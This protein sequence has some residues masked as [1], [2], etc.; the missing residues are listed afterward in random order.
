LQ[1]C[2]EEF[3]ITAHLGVW[4]RGRIFAERVG[5]ESRP[6]EISL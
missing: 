2:L 6:L 4:L 3:E 5:G 1:I